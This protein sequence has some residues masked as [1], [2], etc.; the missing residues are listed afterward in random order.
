[1]NGFEH[2][3]K[4][5]I[6]HYAVDNF[7]TIEEGCGVT[8]GGEDFGPRAVR[9]GVAF[10][11]L[12]DQPACG[13][14]D[15]QT[16]RGFGVRAE[17][18]V[19]T[20]RLKSDAGKGIGT[21]RQRVQHQAQS[22]GDRAAVEGAFAIHKINR[23]GGSGVHNDDSLLGQT[24]SPGRR[25]KAIHSGGGTF[26]KLSTNWR[27]QVV[28]DAQLRSGQLGQLCRQTFGFFSVD[29]GQDD[30]GFGIKFS[31]DFDESV[32]CFRAVFDAFHPF[33]NASGGG[34]GGDG[35]VA[36]GNEEQ[37]AI[38]GH[39]DTV[40]RPRVIFL[41]P[42]TGGMANM[43]D[44]RALAAEERRVL[45]DRVASL[46]GKG[47][48]VRLDA[49][50]TEGDAGAEIY[51]QRQRAGAEQLGIQFHLHTI[52]QNADEATVLACIQGLNADPQVHAM[53]MFLP[54]PE[55]VE[56]ERIQA[57]IDPHK[58]V[59]GVNPAN[60]GNAV[61]GRRSLVPCTALAVRHMLER[62]GV[63][64]CGVRCL[65]VG[66][67]NIVGKPIA[68]LLMRSEATVFSANRFT[69]DL[70]ELARTC[71]VVISAAGAPGLV[72]PD[73]IKPGATVIDVGINRIKGPDGKSHVVGDVET[74]EVAEVAGAIS[75][76]PGGVGPVTVA[77]L[78]RNVVE[79]AEQAAEV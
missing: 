6:W 64:L 29:P 57:A 56:P 28:L 73:W 41:S 19:V 2:A 20:R 67:S 33:K 8:A 77:M 24:P 76:V 31:S 25:Q 18:V 13:E 12:A 14:M 52:P 58:D 46:A 50:L 47:R 17:G 30:R 1:M 54:L 9:Q 32:R 51:A 26:G 10:D 40:P 48:Q 61:F 69:K 11:R 45:G 16:H 36:N 21:F 65:V 63:D 60:I 38:C 59:E 27:G 3:P 55:G 44:G 71:D 74:T 53:M 35:G 22:R 42:M 72:T 43:I 34:G 79:S 68:L 78:L 39:R 15:A 37:V 5:Q 4:H 62:R 75:P 23:D 66:Q 49:I 70:P 7:S